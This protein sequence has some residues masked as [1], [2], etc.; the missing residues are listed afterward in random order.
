VSPRITELFHAVADLP[1]EERKQYF[2]EH[3]VEQET[4][5]EVE[6]LLAFDSGASAFLD[7]DISAAANRALPLVDATVTI[8]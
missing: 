5:L 8:C 7:R 2:A 6:E 4:R 1:P 3:Q